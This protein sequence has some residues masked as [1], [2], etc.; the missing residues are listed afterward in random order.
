MSKFLQLSI[1]CQ[2]LK[3]IDKKHNEKDNYFKCKW[4]NN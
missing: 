4:F 1:I 3:Y 2:L